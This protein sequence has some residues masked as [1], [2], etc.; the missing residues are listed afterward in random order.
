MVFLAAFDKS[1]FSSKSNQRLGLIVHLVSLDNDDF[2]DLVL[3]SVFSK[4]FFDFFLRCDI[5][6]LTCELPFID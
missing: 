6:K 4:K 1:K 5:A 3:L 2:E